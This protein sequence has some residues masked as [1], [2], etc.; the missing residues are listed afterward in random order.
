MSNQF[1]FQ[2]LG[3]DIMIDLLHRKLHLNKLASR[4]L[5][6]SFLLVFFTGVLFIAC[7]II[8]DRH[9]LFEDAKEQLDISLQNQQLL[10][11]HWA[12]D[13]LD[14]VR[15]LA[16]HT[17]SHIDPTE[18][19]Y[20]Q[21]LQDKEFYDQVHSFVF[22]DKNGYVK[23]DTA[24]SETVKILQEINLSDRDYFIDGK[25][26][27]EH[28]FNIVLHN[29]KAPSIIFSTPVFSKN[30]EFQGVIF[31]A[32]LLSK[33]N[34]MLKNSL[35]GDSNQM[36][37][38][39]KDGLIISD[40]S[41]NGTE[42]KEGPT[43]RYVDKQKLVEMIDTEQGYLE[44]K[45]ENNKQMISSFTPLFDGEYFLMNERSKEEILQSHVQVV[46]ALFMI[47]MFI[48]I[49][50]FIIVYLFSRRILQSFSNLVGVI[51][52]R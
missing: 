19:I 10:I 45:N 26:G 52:E 29:N 7:F 36:K 20:Q 49:L 15:L 32:V 50:V 42:I 51:H 14:E 46:K 28:V 9:Q 43:D 25:Q 30:K 40:V 41:Q 33:L 11:E 3:S 37:I 21:I 39:S 16:H 22:I 8:I 47:M 34:D 24:A 27:N 38:V 48:V 4:F 18:D 44:Y 1:L 2:Q 12:T 31:S 35:T 6:W 23:V 17:T 13:R 5:F